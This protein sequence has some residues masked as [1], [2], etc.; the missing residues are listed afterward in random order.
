MLDAKGNKVLTGKKARLPDLATLLARV[1]KKICWLR[2]PAEADMPLCDPVVRAFLNCG[3][4]LERIGR[5]VPGCS[6]EK[7]KYRKLIIRHA[8]ETHQTFFKFLTP[9]F[10]WRWRRGLKVFK[11]PALREAEWLDRFAALGINVVELLG[12]GASHWVNR[13]TPVQKINY[14][15]TRTPL[16]VR[17]ITD[18]LDE[19]RL[20]SPQR[21]LVAGEVR[22]CADLLHDNGIGGLDVLQRTNVLF[23]P[24]TEEVI[25]CDAER[26]RRL[27]W[28]FRRHTLARDS[29]AVDRTLRLLENGSP[30]P[31]KDT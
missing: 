5:A 20:S 7:F 24:E 9:D 14:M 13:A 31:R 23:N 17:R 28:L 8:G 22:R 16:A 27:G 4:D 1:Q 3:G 11:L 26:T 25:L 10:S 21:R 19:G 15:V 6:V 2:R 30:Q 29:R 12:V 18:L